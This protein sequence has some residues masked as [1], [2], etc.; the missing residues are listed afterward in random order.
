MRRLWLALLGSVLVALLAVPLAGGHPRRVEYPRRGHPARHHE[1]HRHRGHPVH[2]FPP[3]H[4]RAVPPTGPT[5]PLG[6]SGRW[7]TDAAGRV[8]IV[9]GF[10]MVYK[11]APYYPAA[12]G[13]DSADAAF[14]KA[15]GFNAVRVGV[16]WKG[17]EPQPG[18]FDTAYLSQISDTVDM[19]ARDGIVSLLDFHQDQLNEQFAGEGFPDWAIQTGG[20]P[21]THTAFSA[22][23]LLNP[24]LQHA[25]DQFWSNAPGPDG[26]GLQSWFAG[27]WQAAAARFA[28]NPAVLGYELFNEPF[29]GT[30]WQ[31]CLLVT[32]CPL[33]DAQLE[34][35]YRLV[36]RAIRSVDPRTLV[37]YEPNVLFNNGVNTTL[38][39]L[40]DPQAGFAFHDY[41]L[42]A[43]SSGTSSFCT[44]SNNLVFSHALAHVART[45]EALLETEFGATNN[46]TLLKDAVARADRNMVPWMEWAFCGCHDPTTV[47]PG[48]VEAVVRNPS[49]PPRGTNVIWS[50]L[51]ALTEPYP[52][53]IAGI[54][55]SFGFDRATGEFDLRYSTARAGGGSLPAGAVT[56]IAVPALDYPHGY[57]VIADGARILSKRGA[58]VLQLVACPSAR[59]ITVAVTRSGITQAGCRR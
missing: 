53:V 7:I 2:G 42:T 22:G 41:C 17:L 13:F 40:G 8:V 24:A 1:H 21:N 12:A 10:N 36:D 52:Q 39:A 9:H 15:N 47:G 31:Q 58:P 50:T 55:L 33:F 5:L 32:G 19:L 44:T 43:P 45:G 16:I 38:P 25:L 49:L 56:D 46:V 23:Y 28:A 29:P 14:L 4:R 51:R 3:R 35:F 11:L 57:S 30:L 18:V 34:S 54:P 48:D 27:A 20:L 6:H 37:F 59:A 26:I